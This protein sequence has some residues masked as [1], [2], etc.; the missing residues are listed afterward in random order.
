MK[1]TAVE[2]HYHLPPDY[3]QK[4]IK[5]NP[6]QWF[7]HHRRFKNISQLIEPVEGE[8]LDIGSADGTFTEVIVNHSKAAKVIGIDILESSVKY[9]NKRFKKDK[10]MEFLVADAQYLPFKKN[11]FQAVFCL[12]ALEHIFDPQKVLSEIKR[13]LK[14]NG[15]LIILVPTDSFLFKIAWWFVLHTWGKHWRETHLQSFRQKNSLTLVVKK[16]GFKIERDK[17]FLLN[18][19]EVVKARKEGK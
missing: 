13:V 19:L 9:A 15:Y 2:L 5:V 12:E 3:Y 7:W 4:S 16:A 1:K 11:R 6:L 8:I 10:R 17:K 18:M 14:P